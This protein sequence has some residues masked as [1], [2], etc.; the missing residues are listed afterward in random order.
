MKAIA[1]AGMLVLTTC[2]G[3]DAAGERAH[4]RPDDLWDR[5]FVSVEV[6]EDGGPRPLVPDTRIEMTFEKREHQGILRWQAGC[7]II[8]SKVEITTRRL[9]V[10]EEFE[11][12]EVGCRGELH[13]Q[14]EWVANFFVSD[15]QWELNEDR[16]T[17]RSDETIV[18][19][20]ALGSDR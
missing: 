20:E 5:T 2:G 19:F 3:V 9:L 11:G 7:N 6:M 18:E 4:Q 10:S 15:P 13:E 12:T 16:L 17:L 8:G 14:D 1:L